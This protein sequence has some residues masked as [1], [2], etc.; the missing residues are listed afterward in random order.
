[1]VDG[2][3][4]LTVVLNK[5]KKIL[6][7]SVIVMQKYNCL[8]GMHKRGVNRG[9]SLGKIRCLDRNKC[10]LF[11]HGHPFDRCYWRERSNKKI[12]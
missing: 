10:R 4:L 3:M 11:P 2:W 9:Q 7:M 1:M 8:A 12:D 5:G 6:G